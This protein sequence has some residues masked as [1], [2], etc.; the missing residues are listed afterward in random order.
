MRRTMRQ[1]SIHCTRTSCER[2]EKREDLAC[3]GKQALSV[4]E[5]QA[6]LLQYAGPFGVVEGQQS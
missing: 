4:D 6:A 3:R 5:R 2:R 1:N